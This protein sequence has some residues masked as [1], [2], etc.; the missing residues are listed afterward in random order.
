MKLETVLQI[1]QTA[2]VCVIALLLFMTAIFQRPVPAAST[3]TTNESMQELA[4]LYQIRH[5]IE[6]ESES[7]S[8]TL[9]SFKSPKLSETEKGLV[10]DFT[11]RNEIL[12]SRIDSLNAMIDEKARTALPKK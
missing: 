8:E 10:K 1:V 6:H 11:K 3:K 12:D 9:K 2:A 4:T 5:H 7:N